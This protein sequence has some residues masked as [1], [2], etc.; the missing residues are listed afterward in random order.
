MRL[1][2][3]GRQVDICDREVQEALQ[4]IIDEHRKKKNIWKG[5]SAL[6]RRHG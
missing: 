5:L 6:A 4:T 1:P 3:D 2:M